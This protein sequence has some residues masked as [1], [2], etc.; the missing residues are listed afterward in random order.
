MVVINN[1]AVTSARDKLLSRDFTLMDLAAVK[2][3][4]VT[5]TVENPRRQSN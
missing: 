4:T 3:E 2:T 1:V 5:C